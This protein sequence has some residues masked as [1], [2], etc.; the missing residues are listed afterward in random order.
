M[1]NVA[2][3][4]AAEIVGIFTRSATAALVKQKAHA[5]N[6]LKKPVARGR[7]R[8]GRE[9]M[10][11]EVFQLSFT[12][13]FCQVGDLAAV[14]L[15]RGETKLFFECL[16]QHLYISVLAKNQRDDEPIVSCAYLS[17]GAAISLE[18]LMLP[19]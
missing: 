19:S 16:L 13:K 1:V 18:G 15:G 8:I 14:E 11:I 17:V 2:G 4:Q 5:I 10:S 12:I 7:S 3:D 9:G 6:I